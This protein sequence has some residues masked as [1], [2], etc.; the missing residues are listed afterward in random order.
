MGISE[1]HDRAS[2]DITSVVG[3][4]GVGTAILL[5][6]HEQS[7]EVNFSSYLPS[8]SRRHNEH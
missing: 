8:V 6:L 2:T 5:V 3:K 4:L 1:F 7:I